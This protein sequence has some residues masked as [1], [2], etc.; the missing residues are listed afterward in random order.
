MG[1]VGCLTIR[2][3]VLIRDS[4]LYSIISVEFVNY[5]SLIYLVHKVPATIPEDP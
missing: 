1:G 4:T 2:R 5:H 3:S